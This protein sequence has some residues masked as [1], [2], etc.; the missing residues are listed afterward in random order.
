MFEHLVGFIEHLAMSSNLE[1]K[2][3]PNTPRQLFLFHRDLPLEDPKQKTMAITLPDDANEP[4]VIE[5]FSKDVYTTM[6]I[7]AMEDTNPKNIIN[8]CIDA[9]NKPIWLHVMN[10]KVCAFAN[11]IS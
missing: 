4:T 8:V 5:E 11:A 10:S 3:F 9:N 2:S 1:V 6:A 7:V